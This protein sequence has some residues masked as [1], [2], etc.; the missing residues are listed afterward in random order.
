MSIVNQRTVKSREGYCGQDTLAA[1]SPATGSPATIKV[2]WLPSLQLTKKH[3]APPVTGIGI[4][5]SEELDVILQ[6]F[7]TDNLR[8]SL[9]GFSRDQAA[10]L[11]I[12]P[13]CRVHWLEMPPGRQRNDIAA[14]LLADMN[15]KSRASQP[16][17]AHMSIAPLCG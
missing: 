8:N 16:V 11:N 9:K 10:A 5:Y 12:D 7:K 6:V 13:T 15:R 4:L 2:C 1:V 14:S 3:M 17:V